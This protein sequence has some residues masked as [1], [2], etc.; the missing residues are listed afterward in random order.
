MAQTTIKIGAGHIDIGGVTY[1]VLRGGGAILRLSEEGGDTFCL[2]PEWNAPTRLRAFLLVG[3][4]LKLRGHALD[5]VDFE[6]EIEVPPHTSAPEVFDANASFDP[7]AGLD[8]FE[9]E[10]GHERP[11]HRKYRGIL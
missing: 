8:A 1:R 5:E 3:D 11:Q 2:I 7:Y 9:D 6:L 4:D 10:D